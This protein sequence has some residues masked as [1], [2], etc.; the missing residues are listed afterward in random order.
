MNGIKVIMT[1]VQNL[2]RPGGAWGVQ[3]GDYNGGGAGH[4]A[5]VSN[6]GDYVTF[7]GNTATVHTR[8]KFDMPGHG[9][10][11]EFS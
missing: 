7:S 3:A 10:G 11:S 1:N 5:V 2:V 9:F 8:I 4:P 6:S